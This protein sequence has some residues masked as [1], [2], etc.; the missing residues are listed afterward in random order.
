M[1]IYVS[2][3]QHSLD[4][5]EPYQ[6]QQQNNQS[7]RNSSLNKDIKDRVDPKVQDYRQSNG[8]HSQLSNYG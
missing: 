3:R 2:T 6:Q 7:I 4:S 8:V 5:R 1:F